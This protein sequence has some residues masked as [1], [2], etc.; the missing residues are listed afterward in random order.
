MPLMTAGNLLLGRVDGLGA[1][2][3]LGRLG[4]F[5]GHPAA[6]ASKEGG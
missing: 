5:E 3:A 4:G 1:L 6:A 2:G